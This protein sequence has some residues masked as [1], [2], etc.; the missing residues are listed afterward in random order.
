[1]TVPA[2]QPAAPVTVPA[3]QPAKTELPAVAPASWMSE[4]LWWPAVACILALVGRAAHVARTPR[5]ELELQPAVFPSPAT[6]AILTVLKAG[7]R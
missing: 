3:A 7:E 2:A 6:H 1:M 5:H 4:W